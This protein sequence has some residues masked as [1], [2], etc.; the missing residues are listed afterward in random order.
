MDVVAKERNIYEEAGHYL[1]STWNLEENP[2]CNAEEHIRAGL[3]VIEA[4]FGGY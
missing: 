3:V 4:W 2:S 1:A